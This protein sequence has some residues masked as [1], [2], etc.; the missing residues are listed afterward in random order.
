MLVLPEDVVAGLGLET[1]RE[2]VVAYANEHRET[3]Q[4]AG[5]VTV[6]IGK[7]CMNARGVIGLLWGGALVGRIVLVV[8]GWV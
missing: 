3:R 1:Q 5:P 4:V 2:V 7:R 6:R 8:A